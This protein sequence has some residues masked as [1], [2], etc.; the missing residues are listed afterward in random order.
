MQHRIS[1]NSLKINSVRLV[2]ELK[3]FIFNAQKK[4]AEAIKGK[5]DDSIMALCLSLYVRDERIRGLPIGSEE[6][7]QN[8]IKIVKNNILEEIKQEI[9]NDDLSS[10]SLGEENNTRES[11]FELKRKNDKILREFG[12]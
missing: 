11:D 2:N 6:S 5:H 4:R 7:S 12:W 9:I 1:N 8:I 10:W 3:T